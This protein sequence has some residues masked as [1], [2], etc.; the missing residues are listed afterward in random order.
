MSNVQDFVRDS[1]VPE[2]EKV[3]SVHED[4]TVMDH[5]H[6]T[7]NSHLLKIYYSLAEGLFVVFNSSLFS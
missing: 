3:H 5:L 1:K 7:E 4:L 6:D 2:G